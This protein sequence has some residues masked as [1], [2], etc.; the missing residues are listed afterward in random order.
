MRK[1]TAYFS[2]IICLIIALT[3]CSTPMEI[4]T[5]AGNFSLSQI[6][7][8]DSFAGVTAPEGRVVM[9]LALTSD[10][11]EGELLDK[12]RPYFKPTDGSEAAMVGAGS[13]IFECE[14]VAL[15]SSLK[16]IECSL[17][18]VVPDDMKSQTVYVKFPGIE[19]FPAK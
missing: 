16:G 1:F 2:V 14:G 5:P 18:F 9:N 11:P 12:A 10:M 15:Y 6:S 19:A 3:G 13:A 4:S 8:S 7:Y 17:V